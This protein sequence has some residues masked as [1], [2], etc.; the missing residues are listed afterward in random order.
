MPILP[1][2]VQYERTRQPN[3]AEALAP[4]AHPPAP[5]ARRLVAL[6]TRYAPAGFRALG[7]AAAAAALFFAISIAHATIRG[8]AD[9]ASPLTPYDTSRLQHGV[10]HVF[11]AE[12][13]QDALGTTGASADVAFVVW[14]TLFFMPVLIAASVAAVWGWRAAVGLLS[15]FAAL[16]LSADAF[17]F[18]LPTRPPWMDV[19]VA[20]IVAAQQANGT[21]LDNNQ[22][23]ALPSLHVGVI[24]AFACWFSGMPGRPARWVARA[25]WLWAAAMAWAIVYTGEHYTID[26]ITGCAWAAVAYLAARRLGLAY[27]R[28]AAT[29]AAPPLAADTS[30]AL[31]PAA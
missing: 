30:E 28:R 22:L 13:L 26:A 3:P 12:R 16:L 21:H 6:N 9:D 27:P 24:A 20:R 23:A 17:Y 8:F 31:A 14:R 5:F 2:A 25:H 4:G 7:R 1:P 29:P 19:D 10:F 15:V 18:I 11:F